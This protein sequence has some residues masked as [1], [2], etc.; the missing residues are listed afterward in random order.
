MVNRTFKTIRKEIKISQAAYS[1]GRS[2]TELVYTFRALIE[3]AVCA[4]DLN[5]HILLL[6]MSRAFDTIDRGILLKDLKEVLE[7]DTLHLVSLLLTDV[8]LEVK[9]KGKIGDRFK[10]DIGSPQGDCSSPI[11]CIFYLHEALQN[12]KLASSRNIEIDLRHDHNYTKE[13][14]YRI[15]PK[16]QKSFIIDQQYADDTSWVTTNKDTIED[17]KSKVP[18]ILTEK[19]LI[20]NE[21]KTEEY[22]ISRTTD[23]EWKKCKYLGSLL[24]NKEDITRRKQLACAAFNK[25]KKSLCSKD[26]SLQIR[27]RI[28]QAL[29]APVFLYN[30]EIWTFTKKE[31]LKIDTFQRNLLRQVIRNRKIKNTKL[32]NICQTKQWSLTIQERRLKWFGHLQRLPEDSPARLAY[33][34]VTTKPV[35]KHKGGQPLTWLKLIERDLNSIQLSIEKASEIAQDRDKYHESI[36]V[37]VVDEAVAKISQAEV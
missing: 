10:P 28:F 12:I 2:T 35:K 13:D 18:K 7:P 27:L 33:K 29:I 37:R 23:T 11:W 34:E 14:K 26:I 17:I 4:E 32:Y 22:T 6:D 36:V 9:H 20:V 30:S 8:Q 31:I 15:T 5:I 24:G 3:Q 25:N 16:I 1:P 21:D 19:N